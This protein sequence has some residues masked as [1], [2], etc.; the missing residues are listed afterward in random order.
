MTFAPI[1]LAAEEVLKRS[2]E[3][4]AKH[5]DCRTLLHDVLEG[6]ELAHKSLPADAKRVLVAC[7]AG[8]HQRA[9]HLGF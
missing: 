5:A 1:E 2:R 7:M 8:A 4:A 3:L 6:V 9:R